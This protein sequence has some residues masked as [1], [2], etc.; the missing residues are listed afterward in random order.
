MIRIKVVALAAGDNI[1]FS[2]HKHYVNHLGDSTDDDDSAHHVSHYTSIHKAR[3][4]VQLVF[5]AFETS[6][7]KGKLMQLAL[8]LQTWLMT[9]E[10]PW[11]E[12][13]VTPK[14]IDNALP[15]GIIQPSFRLKSAKALAVDMSHEHAVCRASNSRNTA[16]IQSQSGGHRS[17]MDC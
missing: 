2:G 9:R 8:H 16:N 6:R 13:N 4:G 10:T 11:L 15:G 5:Y 1:H 3:K 7:A 12:Y 14:K 17:G